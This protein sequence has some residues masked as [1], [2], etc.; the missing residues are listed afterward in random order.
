MNSV[1]NYSYTY[2]CAVDCFMEVAIY[3]FVPHLSNLSVKNEFT[4]LIFNDCSDN[5]N[6]RENTM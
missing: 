1:F 6:S 5:L 3:S 2:S 4:S